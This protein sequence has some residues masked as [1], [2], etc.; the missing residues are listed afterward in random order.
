MSV[1]EGRPEDPADK[2]SPLFKLT[3][4]FVLDPDSPVP[5]YYQVEQILLDRITKQDA[6]GRMLPSEKE[7]M[8]VFGVSR[9]TVKK[10]FNNLVAKGLVERRRAIGTRVI[11][12]EITEDLARL[13]SYTEEM[14]K[15]GLKTSTEVLGAEVE[16]PR[17]VCYQEAPA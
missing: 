16:T 3:E 17:R 7:L 5:L 8:Q 6:V 12:Q 9:A 4:R 13:T 2:Q 15:K 1:S 11:S 10:T 14:E